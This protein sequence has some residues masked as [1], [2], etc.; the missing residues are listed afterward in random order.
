MNEW[1]RGR[2][3]GAVVRPLA[4]HQCG[5][6]SNPGVAAICG[7]SLLLVLSLDPRGFSPGTPVFFAPNPNSIWNARTRFNEFFMNVSTPWVNKLHLQMKERTNK[8]TKE[9][10]NENEW[11]ITVS[12]HQC[13]IWTI[14]PSIQKQE[15]HHAG[16][17]PRDLLCEALCQRN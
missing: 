11:I 9:W 3:G 2:K 10:M 13:S 17:R 14:T 4:S 1:M 8:Q 7:V 6:G 12:K 5:P 15:P 16:I